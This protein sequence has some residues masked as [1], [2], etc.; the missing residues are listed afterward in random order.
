MER[1]KGDG[2]A[3]SVSIYAPLVIIINNVLGHNSRSIRKYDWENSTTTYIVSNMATHGIGRDGSKIVK[4]EV[5]TETGLN[6]GGRQTLTGL[7][8]SQKVFRVKNLRLHLSSG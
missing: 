4:S 8:N 5:K 2:F 3:K 1:H 6:S 7:W